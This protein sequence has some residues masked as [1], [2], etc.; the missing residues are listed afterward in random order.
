MF[1]YRAPTF[2]TPMLHRMVAQAVCR[3]TSNHSTNLLLVCKHIYNKDQL[4][5]KKTKTPFLTVR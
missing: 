5:N 2:R 4:K 1:A 3:N